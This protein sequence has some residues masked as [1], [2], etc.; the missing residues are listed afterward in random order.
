MSMKEKTM[1]QQGTRAAYRPHRM[2][3]LLFFKDSEIVSAASL[4]ILLMNASLGGILQEP[5][6]PHP[7]AI[8][9]GLAFGFVQAVAWEANE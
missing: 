2:R 7:E 5:V 8:S 9:L 1:A 3:K 4:E 6:T